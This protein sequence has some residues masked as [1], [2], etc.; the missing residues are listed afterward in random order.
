[1]KKIILTILFMLVFVNNVYAE[2]VYQN[3][4]NLYKSSN[5]L[6]PYHEYNYVQ[7]QESSVSF[8]LE[9]GVSLFSNSTSETKMLSESEEID[10]KTLNNSGYL[11]VGVDI[12]GFQLGVAPR[13]AEVEDSSKSFMLQFALDVPL[14]PNEATQPFVEVGVQYGNIEL[15]TYDVEDSS[16]G[17][18]VGG[19]I[20]HYFNNNTYIKFLILYNSIEFDTEIYD[21]D[22]SM[23]MSGI[24]FGAALGYVF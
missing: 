7:P 5:L 23:E 18:F 3:M 1:M 11:A 24:E 6:R 13:F 21:I 4:D 2:N 16:F 9:Y 22:V 20:K 8:V 17:Y 14:M 10:D 19:G 15:E 12:H